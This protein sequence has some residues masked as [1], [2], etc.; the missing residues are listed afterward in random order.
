MQALD[1][2]RVKTLYEGTDLNILPQWTIYTC[3][4]GTEYKQTK[5]RGGRV[6]VRFDVAFRTDVKCDIIS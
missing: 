3:N 2:S 1:A 4:I 6:F 5:K